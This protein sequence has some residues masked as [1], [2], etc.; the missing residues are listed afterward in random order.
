MRR[1]LVIGSAGAGKSNFAARLAARTR[2]PLVHLDALY[3]RPGWTEPPRDE[4]DATLERLLAGERWILDG[5]YGRTL[6]RRLAACDT[7]VFLDLPRTVCLR[8]AVWRRIRFHGRSR[9]DMREGCPE[10]LTWAF[11]RWIWRYP[12][13]QRPRVMTQLAALRPGQRA[14]V[15]RSPA[16]VEAFLRAVPSAGA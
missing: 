2:L 15:L 3:W 7:A 11:V 6:E 14:V 5:N 9:P 16:E 8:R 10:R 1:V 13:E 4:W 12:R